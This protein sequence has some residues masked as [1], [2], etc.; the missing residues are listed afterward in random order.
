MAYVCPQL[1]MYTFALLFVK[2]TRL[3]VDNKVKRKLFHRY[4]I[5]QNI[6]PLT[7]I[8]DC[9][10][11][12]YVLCALSDMVEIVYMCMCFVDITVAM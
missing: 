7:A 12:R 11:F 3:L 10:S 6:T 2:A 9:L 1:S 4:D 8:F 5:L